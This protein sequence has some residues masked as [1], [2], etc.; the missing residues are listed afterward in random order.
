LFKNND[1]KIPTMAANNLALNKIENSL[2][3]VKKIA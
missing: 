1:T 2:F 3:G